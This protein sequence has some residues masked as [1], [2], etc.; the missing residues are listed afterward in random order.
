VENLAAGIFAWL[1]GPDEQQEIRPKILSIGAFEGCFLLRV[2]KNRKEPLPLF[3]LEPVDVCLLSAQ[4]ITLDEAWA[5]LE[6]TEVPEVQGLGKDLVVHSCSFDPGLVTVPLDSC[7][8]HSAVILVRVVKKQN[9]V[10]PRNSVSR[11]RRRPRQ[12]AKRPAAEADLAEAAPRRWRYRRISQVGSGTFGKV[13]LAERTLASEG[14]E[15]APDSRQVA[16]KQVA[17]EMHKTRE[18]QILK[19]I[20]HP[21]VVSMLDSFVEQGEDDAKVLCMVLEYLPLNLHQKIGGEPLSV[22][23]VRCFAF[24]ILRALAHLDGSRIVHRDMKPENIL[25]DPDTRA[26]KV[27]D[28]GSAKVLGDGPSSSY[29]CSR[30]WRA[31]ELILGAERYGT[32]VDWWS[33]GCIAAEMM[34]GHPLFMG[35]SS[36]GQMYEIVR[37]LGTP[38]MEEVQAMQAGGD[39]RLAGHFSKLAELERPAKSWE[40]LLPAFA[41]DWQALELTAV[42]LCFDPARRKHPTAAMRSGFFQPLPEDP[43]PL[44]PGIVDFGDVELSSCDANAKMQLMALRHMV[45]ARDPFAELESSV[46]R[47]VAQELPDAKRRRRGPRFVEDLTNTP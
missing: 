9:I 27:A 24:Q 35:E 33:C 25:L 13:F 41:H 1:E 6:Y 43:S 42:L 11:A 14:L 45:E 8:D 12:A 37:S 47:A 22:E 7:G 46:K 28:F 29:I 23:D 3:A 36:W 40:E 20:S 17:H 2:A 30:W 39:G 44:P 19:S 15:A 16:V 5:E 31:P 26:V 18:I 34:L 38:S 4:G 32:S 10:A 21:C